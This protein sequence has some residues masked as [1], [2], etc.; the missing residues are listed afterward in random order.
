MDLYCASFVDVKVLEQLQQSESVVVPGSVELRRKSQPQVIFDML[1]LGFAHL[2][3][4][5]FIDMFPLIHGHGA[6]VESVVLD[7]VC[8]RPHTARE[9]R[10]HM[11]ILVVGDLHLEAR[12][13]EAE[14]RL[15]VLAVLWWADRRFDTFSLNVSRFYSYFTPTPEK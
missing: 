5:F 3:Q 10:M 2:V 9:L 13:A 1:Q 8:W 4:H 14:R 11:S 12:I 15:P 6:Q 7:L